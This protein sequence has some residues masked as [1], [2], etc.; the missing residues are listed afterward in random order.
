MYQLFLCKVRFCLLELRR[1]NCANDGSRHHDANQPPATDIGTTDQPAAPSESELETDSLEQDAESMKGVSISDNLAPPQECSTIPQLDNRSPVVE[2]GTQQLAGHAQLSDAATIPSSD[3]EHPRATS[4]SRNLTTSPPFTPLSSTPFRWGEVSGHI[5]YQNIITAYE[6]QVSWRKNIFSPPTGHAGTDFVKEHTRLLRAYKDKTPLERV[7]LW[8]IMVMPGLLLQKP[9]ATAGSKEFSKHLAR[10][11]VLWKAGKIKELLDEARTIQSRLPAYDTQKGMTSHKLNRRFA[12]LVS[13]GNI[14]A[15]ISLIT[16]YNKGGILDLTPEVRS[17]LDAKHPKAQPA[18]PDVLLR[19]ETPAINPILFECLTDV[20]I[21][22]T[23]LAIQGAA[24]PSMADSY[25]W[26]RM[27]VSFKAASNELCGAVA[28]VARRLATEHVDPL[29]IKP[30]LNN[31]LIPLDKNPG[32]RPI[33]IGETLRRIIGKAVMTV[34]KKD[35]MLAAGV[36]Q[37]CAGHPAG[38]EAAIHALRNIFQD[39]DTDAVLLIDADNAFNRLNRTVALHNVQYTCPPL[40]TIAANFYRSPSR[41]FVTGGME[42]SSAEGTT[43]GCPLSMALYALS[44]IPL[45]DKCRNTATSNCSAATQVWFADDAAAGGRLEA[46]HRF[47]MLLVQHGP[48][49]GYF[50]KSSKTF[51]VVKPGQN[52]DAERAFS[53]TGVQLTDDAPNLE[54]KA[55]QRHLGAAVGSTEYVASYLEE[56]V[57]CWSKQV[58]QLTDVA[59]TEPH[60]AYA[61][62]VFGLRH[63]WTFVQRTMPT[64]DEHMDPLKN[65]IRSRLVPTLTKHEL[66]DLEMELV[67]LPARYG[68]MSFND[69]V[70]DSS[71]KH[72]ESL[73]CTA[74]LT[75]LLVDGA[76]ELPVGGDLD[77][78]A[79]AAIKARHRTALREKADNIQSR[80]PD[81]QRHAMELAREKGGSST[82]TTIPISEHGFC[83]DVKSDFHDHVHLRYCWP[84]DNLPP[85]CPCGANFTIDHAQICKLSGFIHMRHNDPTTFLAQCMKEVHQDVELEPPLQPLSGETFRHLTANTEPDARADI[86]VRGFWTNSRNAFFDTRVFYPHARSYQSRSLPSLYKR[87]ESEKKREYGERINTVEHGS[88][89]PLVFSACGGMGH[90]ATVVVRKLASA[91]ASK[92]RETYSRVINWLRC[93]LSFSL[94]RSAIRC[95]RGSR[96]IRCKNPSTLAPVDLVCAEAHF[97]LY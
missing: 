2:S 11:L 36:T 66:N 44:V 58:N 30:L 1:G 14:H 4:L 94:A 82:L 65:A 75:S 32:V 34:L 84:P 50:P 46:L 53:G 96:S 69:P 22:N 13:K 54:H 47:W 78:D 6:E 61:A 7:A 91:L 70:T 83:F 12:S 39:M 9:Y 24:G 49:Y 55:G 45:I 21:R 72:T 62:F 43:Q 90:E 5:L 57:A 25:V 80:L 52:A 3:P 87:F 16:E 88:F 89:T 20:T 86:R 79:K 63:R 74:I 10:R 26:R 93:R 77:Q 67:S 35:I 29:G 8:A 95:V 41:L 18:S 81:P 37:V 38:C 76:T 19:G 28:D 73:E 51:L 42:L 15:A 92:R 59:S 23:A 71:T 97:D 17:S 85:T 64:A 27:L 56:K 33:G 31:R 68:G 48:A 40:A 60:A